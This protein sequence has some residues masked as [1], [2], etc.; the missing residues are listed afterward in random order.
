LPEAREPGFRSR[1]AEATVL[2]G[3][4]VRLFNVKFSPNLGDGL[5]SEALEDALREL[6]SHPDR[7][8]SVDMAARTSYGPGSASRS[9]LLKVLNRAH[10]TIRQAAIRLPLELM[11]RRRWRPHYEAN[12][13]DADAVVIGGGNLFSDMDLNFPSKMGAVLRLAAHRRLPTAIYGVGVADGWSKTGLSIMRSALAA[14]RPNYVSVRDAASKRRFDDMFAEAA[15]QEARI[16]RDPG[17][18][19]SRYGEMPGAGGERPIGLCI[20]SAIAVTYHSDQD[21]SE[22]GLADWYVELV[23]KLQAF[24]RPIVAFT[25]G[26]PEDEIFLNAIVGRL[27]ERSPDGFRRAT[28]EN[29]TE[30]VRL[31]AGFDALVAHRMHA[32]IAA[33]SYGVP[34]FALRWDA[35]VDAMMQSVGAEG[36]IADAS[37]AN[38]DFV[39]DTVGELLRGGRERMAQ[40]RLRVL[41]EALAGVADLAATLKPAM[42]RGAFAAAG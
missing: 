39:S 16:V 33:Y 3:E 14:A 20:T 36:Q 40:T 37:A 18:L 13:T 8:F 17:F 1:S 38:L 30:L 31:I 11:L 9:L 41:D 23:G 12:L 21:V 34:I 4:A 25:N 35:K 7:T 32:L 6:G 15:G 29:P 42:Q 10:P 27:A 26:S 2:G 5:L 24:G 28:M 19:A 22:G